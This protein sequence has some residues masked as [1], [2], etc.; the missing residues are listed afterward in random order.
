[1]RNTLLLALLLAFPAFAPTH[2]D[3]PLKPS[4]T[5]ALGEAWQAWTARIP[6]WADYTPGGYALK[7]LGRM[8]ANATTGWQKLK[9]LRSFDRYC[10]KG[11]PFTQQPF[12]MAATPALRQHPN[13]IFA[14]SPLF[15]L[16]DSLIER[17][18]TTNKPAQ[19]AAKLLILMRQQLEYPQ[20]TASHPD[21]IIGRFYS[22]FANCVPTAC[23]VA[24][25]RP[26]GMAETMR[27]VLAYFTTY[28]G[29]VDLQAVAL[30][31]KAGF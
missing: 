7:N 17:A 15:I 19:D 5:T 12:C 22:L 14:H 13:D 24:L 21:L 25:T 29:E 10:G 2:A 30:L 3:V 23:Q 28:G 8:G 4:P 27:G 31:R 16:L 6:S 18:G 11:A 26:S 9:N 20:T 1:M